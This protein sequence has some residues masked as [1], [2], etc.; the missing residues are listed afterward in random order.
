MLVI[1]I[2]KTMADI[3]YAFTGL[4]QI[5]QFCFN[6]K[7]ATTF[8]NSKATPIITIGTMAAEN[9]EVNPTTE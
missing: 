1:I 3:K 9:I 7:V 8:P 4:G 6:H 2:N 5:F